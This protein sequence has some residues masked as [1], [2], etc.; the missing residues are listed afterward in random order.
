LDISLHSVGFPTNLQILDQIDHGFRRITLRTQ[1]TAMSASCTTCGTPS[2]RVHGSYWR[3]L[4]DLACFGRPTVLLVR[5]RRFRCTAPACPCR[6]FAEPLP[7][8]AQ[9]RARQTD[10]LRT[11]HRAI[12]L[13]LGGNPGARLAGTLGVPISRAT[14]L[15]RV[16]AGGA[17]PVPPV[18]VLGVDDWAWRKGTR[19]GTILCDLDRRR[20][21]D[22]LP[23]RSAETLAA[24]LTAHPGVSVVVRDRA[25]AYAEGVRKGAPGP[26]RSRTVGICCATAARPCSGFSI[27]TIA[28]SAK[29]PER[30]PR[31]RKSRSRRGPTCGKRPSRPNPSSRCGQPSGDRATDKT[32]AM[33]ASPK[34]HACGSRDCL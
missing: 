29:P 27:S 18:A 6:T 4:G 31:H 19:Y 7:G 25:G 30:P 3:S 9:P 15:T 10:R 21:V 32:A 34:P 14:L 16:R 11:V 2:Q 8:I 33:P 22:L 23:D 13:A 17:E 12:G 5:V 20:V 26:P 1:T 28:I 24:W